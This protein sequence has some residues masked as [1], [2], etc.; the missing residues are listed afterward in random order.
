MNLG[1][2]VPPPLPQRR[3]AP[4]FEP[5]SAHS[6]MRSRHVPYRLVTYRGASGRASMQPNHFFTPEPQRPLPMFNIDVSNVSFLV[7]SLANE[8]LFLHGKNFGEIVSGYATS[9]DRRIVLYRF[10]NRKCHQTV[11]A[12]STVNDGTIFTYLSLS[13]SAETNTLMP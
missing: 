11:R 1:G 12:F 7:P 13:L 4:V 6:I 8:P 5:L 9:R 10:R 3:S 2:H